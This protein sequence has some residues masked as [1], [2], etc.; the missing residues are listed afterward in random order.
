MGIPGCGK[1]TY[2]AQHKN[3]LGED[4]T[5]VSTDSIRASLYGD[6]S[7]QGDSGAVFAQAYKE[8]EAALRHG[9]T[10]YFDATN[11]TSKDRRELLQRLSP[12][13]GKCVA[14]YFHIPLE[15]CKRRN[16]QRDRV[17]PESVL[18]RM[19]RRLEKPTI[20]EGFSSVV[21]LHTRE[22]K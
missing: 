13:A 19:Q 9:G 7:M 14:L 1:S 5:I 18:E 10:V 12:Y 6:T 21:E 17:V 15:V 16:Q 20:E 2:S 11:I 8:A 3:E 22:D 4:V